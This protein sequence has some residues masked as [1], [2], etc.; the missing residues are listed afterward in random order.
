MSSGSSWSAESFCPQISQITQMNEFLNSAWP[1]VL[2]APGYLFY[3]FS[4][5]SM[6]A[7]AALGLALGLL[8]NRNAAEP[9]WWIRW[10]GL[11]ALVVFVV[12]CVFIWR[13]DAGC[14]LFWYYDPQWPRP[15]PFPDHALVGF[16][17]WLDAQRP[18]PPEGIKIHG[19]IQLVLGILGWLQGL[20]LLLVFVRL[21]P[22]FARG[23]WLRRRRSGNS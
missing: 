12:S 10:V 6:F 18:A 1:D 17:D 15:W 8:L 16:H 22:W 14:S 7:A 2:T 5:W 4:P 20:S 3:G 23:T 9:R 21:A 13:F 11:P 19:E